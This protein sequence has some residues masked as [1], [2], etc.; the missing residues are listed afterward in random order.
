MTGERSGGSSFGHR[1]P[2]PAYCLLRPTA[3]ASAQR[4]GLSSP[5]ASDCSFVSTT[6]TPATDACSRTESSSSPSLA[7]SRTAVLPSS[8]TSLATSGTFSA[9]ERRDRD[10]RAPQWGRSRTPMQVCVVVTT[11]ADID[12]LS[13]ARSPRSIRVGQ[14]AAITGRCR[15][16]S[17]LDRQSDDVIQP[18]TRQPRSGTQ[19]VAPRNRPLVIV[20]GDP[21][22]RPAFGSGFWMVRSL[23]G[24]PSLRVV[25]LAFGMRPEP[26]TGTWLK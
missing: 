19:P 23:T 12:Q 14:G 2:P 15:G 13:V 21:G 26:R 6:S 7:M 3:S 8:S 10:S 24:C 11:C 5:D 1:V 18:A 9:R 20:D 4:L 22:V 16:W 17:D 25:W